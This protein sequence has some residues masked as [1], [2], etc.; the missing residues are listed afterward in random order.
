MSNLKE[1]IEAQLVE[2]LQPLSM[3]KENFAN[4]YHELKRSTTLKSLDIA[5][6]LQSHAERE[7]GKEFANDLYTHE[8][9]VN[10]GG[11]DEY[12]HPELV[13]WR[14]KHNIVMPYYE[15]K[16]GASVTTPLA[17]QPKPK[18]IVDKYADKSNS[19]L[20]TIIRAFRGK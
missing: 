8:H 17:S 4:K 13:A 18:S 15:K 12:H 11:K 9:R 10:M 7:H 14:K 3:T 2:A 6:D 20:A 16:Y 1:L 5:D 19:P